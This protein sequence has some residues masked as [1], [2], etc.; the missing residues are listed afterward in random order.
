MPTPVAPSSE[1]AI[2]DQVC[3]DPTALLRLG[4]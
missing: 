3:D 4:A 1:S 2:L